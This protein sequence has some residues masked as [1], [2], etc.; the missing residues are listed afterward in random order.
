MPGKDVD[1]SSLAVDVEGEFRRR[2][3]AEASEFREDRVDDPGVISIDQAVPL[4]AAPTELEHGLD[5]KNRADPPEP[6]HRYA[7]EL[8]A[9]QQGYDLLVDPSFASDIVLAQAEI[10]PHRGDESPG[11]FVCHSREGATRPF[12]ATYLR[13]TGHFTRTM[14][15][16][17]R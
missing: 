9:L 8:P 12:A 16:S 17:A 6:L 11:L 15:V 5:L 10:P 4:T 13:I 14:G 3:P 2:L 1:R 7:R